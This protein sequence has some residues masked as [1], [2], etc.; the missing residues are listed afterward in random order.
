MKNK[1]LLVAL[2]SFL[3]LSL[4]S[5]SVSAEEISTEESVSEESS[6]EESIAEDIDRYF[7]INFDFS[8][9]YTFGSTVD[10]I[11]QI[12]SN[13][14][15]SVT[16]GSESFTQVLEADGSFTLNMKD[17][18]YANEPMDIHLHLKASPSDEI[19]RGIIS[20]YPLFDAQDF[21]VTYSGS[22]SITLA[23][24]LSEMMSTSF[25]LLLLENSGSGSAIVDK[26]VE[27]IEKIAGSFFAGDALETA[28][29]I[30]AS[31]L[32]DS[33]IAGIYNDVYPLAFALMILIWLVSVGKSAITTE[34]FNKDQ[35]LKP[36][37]RLLWSM[38]MLSAS[39][40][41]LELIFS[42]FHGL[43][44]QIS[45]G[46]PMSLVSALLA[47]SAGWIDD[48]WVVGGIITFFNVILAL[49]KIVVYVGIE[50]IFGIVFYVIIFIRF[51]KLAVLQ[52][53]SPFFF[54]CSAGEKT[55]RYLASFMREYIVF[56]AQIFIAIVMYS[57]T[58]TIYGTMQ[59]SL[60]VRP[61][62]GSIAY[63]AGIISVAG[64]GKFIRSLMQ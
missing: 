25:S 19:I 38:T 59:T 26:V 33:V 16:V 29:Q 44:S 51:V 34:L 31:E 40:P 2:C 10:P 49:P 23:V 27:T 47:E 4:F 64:S 42:L 11:G 62:I 45:T 8:S 9:I 60:M 53:I 12:N 43:A 13:S 37:L 15:L 57:L 7:T 39:M 56:G 21:T 14:L 1:T 5:L 17:Y 24:E 63:I 22:D 52:S 61:V 28:D 55:E 58:V 36:L 3:L 54:A 48:S 32:L 46:V 20:T 18:G 41:V 30:F 6:E 50:V 35:M